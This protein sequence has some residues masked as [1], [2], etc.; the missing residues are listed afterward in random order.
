MSNDWYYLQDDTKVGPF[1]RIKMER[2]VLLGKLRPET[3]VQSAAMSDW[4]EAGRH[5][6]F[7]DAPS[8]PVLAD[9]EADEPLS[10]IP[11]GAAP[12]RGFSEAISVCLS[13]YAT[14]SGRASRSEYWWFALF[15]GLVGVGT[16][17][18]DA[19]FFRNVPFEPLNS[20]AALALVLPGVAVTIRRLHD[21]DRSG[22]WVG[23]PL[24]LAAI[25][26]AILFAS[27][28]YISQSTFVVIRAL[29]IC[30]AISWFLIFLFSLIP[31][32][33]RR[34]RFG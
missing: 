23:A 8:A 26:L 30:V 29:F 2:L 22:W 3:L 10:G 5:F 19:V 20:L 1:E 11:G 15:T 4:E 32:K 31:G 34:N 25:A 17:A 33:P 14:F 7:D 21:I 18:A 24:I 27:G 6:R 28:P 9:G 12:Y 13:K 16:G